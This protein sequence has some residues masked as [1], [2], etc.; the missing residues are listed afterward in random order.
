MKGKRLRRNTIVPPPS[1]AQPSPAQ[2]QTPARPRSSCRPLN[3]AHSPHPFVRPFRPFE[4]PFVL[5][6]I[7]P[8]LYSAIVRVRR[9]SRVPTAAAAGWPLMAF[10][11][12]LPPFLR[13]RFPAALA[14][15]VGIFNKGCFFLPSFLPPSLRPSVPR[16]FPSGQSVQQRQPAFPGND[17]LLFSCRPRDDRGRRRLRLLGVLRNRTRRDLCRVAARR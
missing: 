10:P 5:R 9:S 4:S 3:K 11:R 13:F 12:S 6:N 8:I 2:S 15:A 14:A 1:P 17:L 16:C 7:W